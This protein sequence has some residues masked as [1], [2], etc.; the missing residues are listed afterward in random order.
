MIAHTLIVQP[1][2]SA[3]IRIIEARLEVL[4]EI[5][6]GWL[7]AIHPSSDS[8]GDWH[9]YVDEEGKLKGLPAATAIAYKCGWMPHGD[10]LCGPVAFFGYAS[11]GEEGDVPVEVV[12]VATEL[13]G[14]K[15]NN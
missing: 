14:V 1:D 2:G 4:N 9:A 11:N 6:G 8:H 3:E 5:V 12:E 15:T 7:E 10:F 13:Y